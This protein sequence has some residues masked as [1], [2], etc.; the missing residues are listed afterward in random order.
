MAR[1]GETKGRL[2][3]RV[4]RTALGYVGLVMG[5]RGLRYATLPRASLAEAEAEALAAGGTFDLRDPRFLEAGAI[6]EG[7]ARGEPAPIDRYP[8]DLPPC[9][10][11]QRAVWLTLREIPRGEVRSY[12]WLAAR[13]GRPGA[14]RAIGRI[15][16][17]N[18][19]PLWLPC[20]RVV[21]ADGSLHGYGGGLPLKERLLRLE[22]A[23][24]ASSP[25]GARAR[26]TR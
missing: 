15:V 11:L 4:V 23:L 6:V 8:V 25:A 19:L 12:G 26:P 17:S 7:Y 14:A 10:G 5:P 16:G 1:N 9:T 21:A 20:H 13:V 2:P 24:A 18:P 3:A 22:G